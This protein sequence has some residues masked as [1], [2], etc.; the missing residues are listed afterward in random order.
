MFRSLRQ[1]PDTVIYNGVRYHYTSND[2]IPFLITDQGSIR[3]GQRGWGH[4]DLKQHLISHYGL[5]LNK[6]THD[7]RLGRFFNVEGN[8]WVLST[9][10]SPG[11]QRN[12]LVD[13]V[14]KFKAI[15]HPTQILYQIED[16]G[17]LQRSSIFIPFS[18]LPHSKEDY[19][20]VQRYNKYL[21]KR[22]KLNKS[23]KSGSK[24]DISAYKS[25][26]M[27]ANPELYFGKLKQ[28]LLLKLLKAL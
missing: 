18:S 12:V 7:Y 11:I 14:Q 26:D 21:E 1:N 19:K 15:A 28:K 3:F 10:A 27:K 16:L 6:N 20:T 23:P 13:V 5:K 4:I 17:S 24:Y 9:W 25:K 22:A 2:C 8:T